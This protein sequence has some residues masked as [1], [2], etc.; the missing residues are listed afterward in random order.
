MYFSVSLPPL[1]T[2]PRTQ[3]TAFY[4]CVQ[5]ASAAWRCTRERER[6]TF[7]EVHSRSW[8]EAERGREVENTWRKNIPFQFVYTE[9]ECFKINSLSL[10]SINRL[11]M[12]YSRCHLCLDID[13]AWCSERHWCSIWTRRWYTHITMRCQGIQWSLE[14]RTISQLRWP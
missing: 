14:R 6:F 12:N 1:H 9:F 11:N 8:R 13:W 7:F 3:L 2:P 4:I 5:C 10:S